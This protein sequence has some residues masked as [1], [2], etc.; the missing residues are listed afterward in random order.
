MDGEI[1]TSIVVGGSNGIGLAISKNLIDRGYFVKILDICEP[2]VTANLPSNKVSYIYCDLA[3]FDEELFDNIVTDTS[4]CAL[5]ITSGIGRV[6]SFENL[7]YAEIKKTMR[8]NAEAVLEILNIFYRKI[9][10]DKPFYT[11]VMGS[12]AG[13]VSSPLF[14]T[15]AASKA[16]VC[17]FGESLN[18]ELAANK[19]TNRILTV[20]P[21]SIPGTRFNGGK[22]DLSLL[23]NLAQEIT[24]RMFHSEEFYIPDYEK[25]FKSVIERY[26]SDPKA[27]GIQSYE[28]KSKSGRLKDEK[29]AV[30]G[31]LSGTFDL[32][33]IGHLNLLRQAKQYCDYLIVGVHES[34]AWKGKETFIPLEDRMNIVRA[35]RYVDKVVVSE[36]E[37]CDAWDKYHY[38]KLF[39]GSDYEGTE[40]FKRYEEILKGKAEIIYFPYTK[41]V[42]SGKIRNEI[43][44]VIVNKE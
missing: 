29:K 10:S 30:I 32:F 42:S 24:D 43:M 14:A 6:C 28:Y 15:Y 3:D 12:I 22:N 33:H 18:A 9:K 21:G 27:F 13:L 8:I 37:D 1:K 16:A 40:R 5:V 25:T 39:V 31:Y 38:T 26:T 34:G 17:R 2:D 7:H 4:V 11:C 23:E 41:K 19:I 35:C 20:S 44:S 36:H